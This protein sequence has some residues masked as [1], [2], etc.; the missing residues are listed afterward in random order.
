[1]NLVN[2]KRIP[3]VADLWRW[4]GP[5]AARWF[6]RGNCWLKL[7]HGADG[8]EIVRAGVRPIGE[9]QRAAG[10]RGRVLS[11]D[12]TLRLHFPWARHKNTSVSK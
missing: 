11:P 6:G 9:S 12:A 3:K 1:M 8:P 2:K 5:A 10:V 4:A 7:R